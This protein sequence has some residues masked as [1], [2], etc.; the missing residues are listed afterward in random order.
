[1]CDITLETY[2]KQL[3]LSCLISVFEVSGMLWGVWV[4]LGV[5]L[6]GVGGVCCRY[7][8]GIWGRFLE[9]SIRDNYTKKH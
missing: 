7:L 6:W 1:M 8:V 9:V 3:V 2:T 5:Y 4:V